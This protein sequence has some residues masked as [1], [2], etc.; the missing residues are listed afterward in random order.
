MPG[1]CS[2]SRRLRLRQGSRKPST[3][4]SPAP[5]RLP[6][7]S[8]RTGSDVAIASPSD[9][10]AP[11]SSSEPVRP[12]PRHQL[13][14]RGRNLSETLS[15]KYDG[16]QGLAIGLP[17][18]CVR[19]RMTSLAAEYLSH[20]PPAAVGQRPTRR[21]TYRRSHGVVETTAEDHALHLVGDDVARDE[22]EVSPMRA[23]LAA[24][25]CG[26]LER[27]RRPGLFRCWRPYFRRQRCRRAP[28]SSCT[29]SPDPARYGNFRRPCARMNAV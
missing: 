21:I 14:V 11:A 7:P 26:V 3:S 22:G 4:S 17:R 6:V 29:G 13:F 1:R 28:V 2:P 27:G 16:D 5:A 10:L 24:R 19:D 12:R 8:A 18:C 15:F 20:H 23:G 9:E 25:P